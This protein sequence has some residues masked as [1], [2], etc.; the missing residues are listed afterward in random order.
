MVDDP[1]G[2]CGRHLE[3]VPLALVD[4]PVANL[5]RLEG[6]CRRELLLVV[7]LREF[8]PAEGGFMARPGGFVT[9]PGGFLTRP[10]GFVTRSDGFTARP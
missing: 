7:L 6:H 9:R 10:D 5:Q 1:S 3:P 8:A 4:E 2:P